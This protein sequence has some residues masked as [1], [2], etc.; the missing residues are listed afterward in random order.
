ML[1]FGTDEVFAYLQLGELGVLVQDCTRA[2]VNALEQE[3]KFDHPKT[4]EK[5]TLLA[6]KV[7]WHK[8][9]TSLAHSCWS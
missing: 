4:Q 7:L 9:P 3:A 8:V 5:E 1:L 6:R 2:N